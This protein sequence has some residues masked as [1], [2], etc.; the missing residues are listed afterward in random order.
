MICLHE[1]QIFSTL[2]VVA[3]LWQKTGGSVEDHFPSKCAIYD[4]ELACLVANR[5][6]IS[7]NQPFVLY[8]LEPN[9]RA[10]DNHEA[11]VGAAFFRC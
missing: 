3:L 10:F 8:N 9:K 6:Q 7:F 4:V 11:S 1:R 2:Q 5:D